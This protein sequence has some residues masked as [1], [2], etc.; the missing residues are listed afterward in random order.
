[1]QILFVQNKLPFADIEGMKR[2]TDYREVGLLG[3]CDRLGR[4]NSNPEAEIKNIEHF[5][6]AC[7]KA[8]PL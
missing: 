1:M 4:L 7:E 5:L 6:Q 8:K 2:D 3:L